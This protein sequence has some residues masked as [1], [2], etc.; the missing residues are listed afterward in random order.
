MPVINRS[1]LDKRGIL[2]IVS[3]YTTLRPS[4]SEYS[5]L[6]PFHEEDTPSFFVNPEK[7]L[8]YCFGCN[9]GGTKETF[10]KEIGYTVISEDSP[11]EDIVNYWHRSLMANRKLLSE[12]NTLGITE[13]NVVD[14]NIGVITELPEG[15]DDSVLVDFGIA[16][17]TKF[18]GFLVFPYYTLRGIKGFVIKT[19]S[20][21]RNSKS[22]DFSVKDN[23]F[24]LPQ[25]LKAIKK[26]N[27]VYVV[28]GI[29]DLMAM[30]NTG[31]T[32]SI[33][34]LGVQ[35]T[36][37]QIYQLNR[38]C[39]RVI[40]VFDGDK[41]GRN[42]VMNVLKKYRLFP[43]VSVV[44]LPEDEDPNS[45]YLTNQ[46]Q[47]AIEPLSVSQFLYQENLSLKQAARIVAGFSSDVV[48]LDE[49]NNLAEVYNVPSDVVVKEI[50]RFRPQDKKLP[51]PSEEEMVLTYMM[52]KGI[53]PSPELFTNESIK[54]AL[55]HDDIVEIYKHTFNVSYPYNIKE[56][57]ERYM[58]RSLADII[59][60]ADFDPIEILVAVSVLRKLL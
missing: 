5:G 12:L 2:E 11:I 24:G 18:V 44:L 37:K 15:M 40:F 50:N 16:N 46:L 58:Y 59:R 4:G 47:D 22:S 19:D 54:H 27:K 30:H 31:L 43:Y 28:E 29:R 6:C 51:E 52:D 48:A 23:F 3:E 55:A 26:T 42:G 53:T 34:A 56:I 20:G 13:E 7:E 35:I 8:W 38:L 60:N 9:R 1:D 32:N 21:Y 33:A 57:V 17:Y 25:A 45:L 41:A 36:P 10:V 39:D 49:A 14:F